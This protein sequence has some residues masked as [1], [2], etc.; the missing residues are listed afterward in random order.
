[1][2]FTF[3]CGSTNSNLK[4]SQR[5][6]ID[7]IIYHLV[8]FGQL[9]LLVSCHVWIF[10]FV[11]L[12]D[13][14]VQKWGG[15]NPSNMYNILLLYP[16][17]VIVLIYVWIIAATGTL[18]EIRW[19]SSTIKNATVTK[20]R[21]T[22]FFLSTLSPLKRGPLV[23][24]QALCHPVG[25]SGPSYIYASRILFVLVGSIFITNFFMVIYFI[26]N[27]NDHIQPMYLAMDIGFLSA[28]VPGLITVVAFAVAT[29]NKTPPT[30]PT[31][32]LRLPSLRSVVKQHPTM[33]DLNDGLPYDPTLPQPS[34]FPKI[35]PYR[36]IA[37]SIPLAIG[38][39]KAVISQKGGVAIPITLEWISGIVIFLV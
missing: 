8:A 39:V 26:I 4:V 36:F 28:I 27:Q 5:R 7:R 29:C 16:G 18:G 30:N 34:W 9:L 32:P 11:C 14:I 6:P 25:S 33:T 24:Q 2:S 21:W 17:T 19:W 22:L 37:F 3:P 35:S 10:L 38:T 13:P 20:C 31:P 15:N 23:I 1:M 12:S